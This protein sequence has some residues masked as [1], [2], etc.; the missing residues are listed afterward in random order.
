M[1]GALFQTG[2]AIDQFDSWEKVQTRRA[3][4]TDRSLACHDHLLFHFQM[5]ELPAEKKDE[6]EEEE[7]EVETYYVKYKGLWVFYGYMTSPGFKIL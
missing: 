3:T 4:A 2:S 6:E 7:E 5:T 1:N